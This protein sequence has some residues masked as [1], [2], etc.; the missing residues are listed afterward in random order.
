MASTSRKRT[1][2]C[3]TK[4]NPSMSWMLPSLPRGEDLG[5]AL[6]G[7][8]C[9]VGR[10]R[11]VQRAAN[12]LGERAEGEARLDCTRNVGAVHAGCLRVLEP[13][14]E[15]HPFA[16]ALL[17]EVVAVDV[18]EVRVAAGDVTTGFH[19]RLPRDTLVDRVEAPSGFALAE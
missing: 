16:H 15:L 13:E 11:V 10:L 18:G 5:L 8:S 9:V 3:C 2:S 6:R 17:E 12:R 1:V 4:S 14:R 19:E 7:H